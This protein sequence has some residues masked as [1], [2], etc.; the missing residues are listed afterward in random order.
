MNTLVKY[1][2]EQIALVKEMIAR[3]ATDNELALFINQ[4]ERTGLDPFSRQIYSIPRWNS[5]SKKM[6]RAIQI[7]IDGQRL[8]AERTGKYQGQL[9]PLWC[10]EDGEWK[11]VWLSNE[12]PAAA[13]VAVLRDGFTSPLWAVA[14]YGAYL[15]TKKD[16]NPNTFWKR[17]PDI[18]LAK[19]AE[20]LALRKAFPQEMSGLYTAE[21]MQNTDAVAEY[22]VV[23]PAHSDNGALTDSNPFVESEPPA[24]EAVPDST[25]AK[26]YKWARDNDRDGGPCSDKQYQFL[27]GTIDMITEKETHGAILSALLSR[28][29]SSDNVPSGRCASG[30]LDV[31]LEKTKNDDGE[32]VANPHYRE[33]AVQCIKELQ[34]A[35]DN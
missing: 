5:S 18:M 33:N 20:S 24:V 23:Q 31:L 30:L 28:A 27:A 16:G 8:I 14:R 13:K 26:I 19:C 2:N 11:D 10:G 9:G 32:L 15:Q 35:L 1:D 4:C 25:C 17:M 7:S 29:V 6:E 12:P 21:E 34:A 3:D 22:T